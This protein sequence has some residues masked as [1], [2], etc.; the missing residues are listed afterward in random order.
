M[1]GCPSQSLS[2]R[3]QGELLAADRAEPRRAGLSQFSRLAALLRRLDLRHDVRPRAAPHARRVPAAGSHRRAYAPPDDQTLR[4]G[5]DRQPRQRG[6]A[7]PRMVGPPGPDLALGR[8]RGRRRGGWGPPPPPPP[9]GRP[10]RGPPE[11][12]SP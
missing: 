8:V 1:V 7:G 12:E 11:A 9:G 10:A 3:V 6:A 4:R 2:T 5:R